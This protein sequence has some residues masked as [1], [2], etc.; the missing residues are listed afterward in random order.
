MTIYMNFRKK[1][2]IVYYIYNLIINGKL[3]EKL[4]ILHVK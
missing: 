2:R 1:L 4:R 3:Y